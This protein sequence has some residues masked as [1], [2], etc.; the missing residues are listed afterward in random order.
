MRT[1]VSYTGHHNPKHLEVDMQE[2]QE[3]GLDDDVEMT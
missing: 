1:G 3:L 2:M